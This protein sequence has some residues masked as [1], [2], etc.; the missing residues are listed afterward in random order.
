MLPIPITIIGEGAGQITVS[1]SEVRT[2]HNVAA[3]GSVMVSKLAGNNGQITIDVQQTSIAH[4]KLLAMFN[5]LVQAA[6]SQWANAAMII[7][8]ITDKTG[9]ICTGI[10][11]QKVPDK[12]YAKAGAN[13]SWTLMAADIESLTTV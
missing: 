6:P 7:K 9:Q 13:V 4:K 3:D 11:L 1:M 8:N 5:I 2:E 12:T 10:S